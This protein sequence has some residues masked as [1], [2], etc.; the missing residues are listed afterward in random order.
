M[1]SVSRGAVWQKIVESVSLISVFLL[2]LTMSFTS[3]RK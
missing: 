2:S 3:Y 1:E